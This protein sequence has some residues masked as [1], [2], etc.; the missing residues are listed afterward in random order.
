MNG[1]LSPL[2]VTLSSEPPGD[3]PE[4]K[5]DIQK[6]LALQPKVLYS[7]GR[8]PELLNQVSMPPPPP[9]TLSLSPATS[10]CDE[11]YSKVI[12]THTHIHTA[13]SRRRRPGNGGMVSQLLAGFEQREAAARGQTLPEPETEPEPEL[14]QPEL[15]Q[16]EPERA[17]PR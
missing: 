7:P 2:E 8:D 11:V 13:S 17:P 4:E 5:M 15:E 3:L 1:D 6:V 14:E 12:Y 16:P 10:A 9:L